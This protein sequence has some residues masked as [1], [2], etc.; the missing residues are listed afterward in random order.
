MYLFP[1]L[2]LKKHYSTKALLEGY[3]VL[4]LYY[5][6]T[7]PII[8]ISLVSITFLY[9]PFTLY[10]TTAA[11]ILLSLVATRANKHL[12]QTLKNIQHVEVLDYDKIEIARSLIDA[13]LFFILLTSYY[14]IF[15]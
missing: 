7:V 5:A 11:F 10:F 4:L 13:L 6:I 2:L 1:F 9:I 3:G 15:G 12:L 8:V 14:F